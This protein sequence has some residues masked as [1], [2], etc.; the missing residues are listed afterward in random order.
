MD[1]IKKPIVIIGKN[2][3]TGGR[4]NKRLVD[5]GIATRPVSRNSDI[6][7]D[8]DR[9]ETWP[10]V[11]SG[12]SAVYVAYQPDLAIPRAADDIQAFIDV[13]KL[14]GIEHLVLLSG[15]GEEGAEK[16]ER[17]LINSGLSWNIVRASWFNQNFSEGFMAEGIL[18]GELV[19][20]VGPVLEPFIDVDDIA[21][22]AVAALTGHVEKNRLLE[23]TG[24]ELLTFQS[25]VDEIAQQLGRD[26][27]LK[28]VPISDYLAILKSQSVPQDYQWLLKELFTV[29]FDGRNASVTDTVEAVIGR[30]ATTF[31]QY[32]KKTIEHG[33]WR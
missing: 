27:A 10:Q 13:A 8:W 19:L 1:K 5:M 30:P 24:P 12:A 33:G 25:C 32:V 28:P 4:V 17:T 9:R 18:K 7:F 26:V 29:V 16:A 22:V 3:K 11:L 14:H 20:P 2:A 21:Q 23:V 15:R 6:R 31:A